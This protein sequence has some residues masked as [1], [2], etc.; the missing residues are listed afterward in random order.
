MSYD[1][2]SHVLRKNHQTVLPKRVLYLD[3]ETK[4]LDAGNT[5]K[6]RLKL[7]WTCLETYGNKAKGVNDA[8]EIFHDTK[9]FAEYLEVCALVDTPLWVIGHNV[10][11]DLQS[12]DFFH[13][14]T[15]SGWSLD[16]VYDKGLTYILC[17]RK[18]RRKIKIVSSTNYYDC[19]LADLGKLIGLPKLDV[20]FGSASEKELS[21]YCHRDVEIVKKAMEY[22]FRFI[23]EHDLGKFSMTKSSQAFNAYRHRFMNHKLYRHTDSEIV[24]LERSAYHGGRTECF[25]Y[26]K[27]EEDLYCTLDINSMY[28]FVMKSYPLPVKC[29][30]FR[31]NVQ[32]ESIAPLL[33]DYS[34]VAECCIE[35][36]EP[37]YAI[38]YNDKTVFP[39][40]NFTAFLCTPGVR[41]AIEHGHL[42]SIK[43]IAIYE[44]Q[45]I[46]AEYV[47]YFFELRQQY[48]LA[49]NKIMQTLCKYFMN[50]LYGKFGQKNTVEERKTEMT[51]DG[52]KRIEVYDCITGT[53][54]IEYKLFNT[55]VV[56][57]GEVEGKNSM[58]AIPAHITEYARFLLWGFIK[59][60][61]VKNLYYCDT[62]SLKMRFKDAEVLRPFIDS[63]RLGYL[64]IEDVFI[65]FILYGCKYY[66]TDDKLR[67]KG[68]PKVAHYLGNYQWSYSTFLRQSSHMKKEITRY[69]IVEKTIKDCTP[70][71]DKGIVT[72]S[73]EVV[74]LRL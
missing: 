51:K 36:D 33:K 46:F 20:K 70:M 21:E 45:N 9:R 15:L 38:K 49:K 5:V 69:Y 58:V 66:R 35:T 42:K 32:P 61:G 48:K 68:V 40:G 47:D 43:Q 18:G 62:D 3:V 63:E 44:Q 72:A 55:Y 27:Q 53:R 34:V 17:I 59:K 29:I 26:G 1:V 30:D 23:E 28:P 4:S 6:H 64:K 37:V 24:L 54:S 12:S 39:V 57:K 13:Y 14:F 10:F 7:A 74:P 71:Y 31:K 16:F 73:G 60:V 65:E 8:W 41:Y 56:Q 50:T 25:R 2:P 67:I 52:Y 22:Y 11:F 19:S